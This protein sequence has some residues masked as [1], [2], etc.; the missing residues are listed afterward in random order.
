MG[1]EQVRPGGG[2]APGPALPGRGGPLQAGERVVL[3]DRKDRR[4]L[5]VLEAGAQWHSH[6]GVLDHDQII[7]RQEGSEVRTSH[8]MALVALRPTREDYVLEMRR[9]AQVVY[10]K[11][12]ALILAL[13]DVRPGCTVVEAGAGS[14]ALTLALL[15]AVGPAGRVISYEVR[16]DHLEVAEANVTAFH[17]GS[18]PHWEL[19]HADLGE[20]VGDLSC[21]RMVLDLLRPWELVAGAGHALHPGGLLACWTPNVTQVMRLTDRLHDDGRFTRIRTVE[22]LLRDWN[23]EG[24]SVRP[25]HRMVA[26]TGF[27]TVCRRV[28]PPEEGGPPP[29][30]WRSRGLRW[31]EE[32]P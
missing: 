31:V 9:G 7:G 23:V 3:T 12:Q 26:H 27:V 22:S 5:L 10:P 17:G 29:P 30:R 24:L 19:R 14:G 11:D 20:E 15:D 6:G 16:R 21:D 25:H 28:P 8:E 32:A 1:E 4:Y 13:G 18:P 2:S